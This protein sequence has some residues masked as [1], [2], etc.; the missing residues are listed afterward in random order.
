[1]T[2]RALAASSGLARWSVV[3]YTNEAKKTFLP[4]RASERP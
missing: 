1:M 2:P 3:D 4:R